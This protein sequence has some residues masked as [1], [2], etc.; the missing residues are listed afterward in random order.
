M[1]YLVLLRGVAGCGKSTWIEQNNLKQYTLCADD[2]R[3]LIQSPV[4]T[5]DGGSEISQ[6]NDKQVWDLLRQLLEKRMERGEFTIIDATH[7]RSSS[8]NE[9]YKK[10]CD[11]YRYRC[12][13]VDFSEISLEV[14]KYRNLSRP[15]YKRVPQDVIENM[16]SRIQTQSLPGWVKGIKPEEF[17]TYFPQVLQPISLSQYND[18][19][20]FGDIHGC[21]DPLMEW[22]TKV[23][24][25]EKTYYIF[26]GDYIDRG[27]Q[28]RETLEFLLQYYNKPNVLMLEGNHERWLRMYANDEE[29]SIRSSEFTRYTMKQLEG[30]DKK[31]LRE[32][33]RKLGQ[34][35]YFLFKNEKFLVTHGGIPTLPS[36]YIASEEYILGVGKYEQYLQVEESFYNKYHADILQVHAHR[37]TENSP[38]SN[39][40]NTCYNL[41]DTVEFGGYLRILSIYDSENGVMIDTFKIKN[42]TF[43]VGETQIEVELPKTDDP[44]EILTQL[45]SNKFIYEKKLTD[46][47]SSFNYTDR[48]FYEKVWNEQTQRARGLFVNTETL[49]VVAR[50]YDKFFNVDENSNMKLN[51]LRRELVFPID[52]YHKYNGFLGLVGFDSEND[53]LF[54]S[55]KSSNK[56]D[57]SRWFTEILAGRLDI[58]NTFISYIKNNNVCFVFEVIDMKNDPHIIDYGDLREVIL[59]DV[60]YR[61]FDYKKYSYSQL[62]EVGKIFN[63]PVKEKACTLKDYNELYEMYENSKNNFDVREGEGYVLEDARG[64]MFKMK[65][66]YYKFWKFMRG[67]KQGIGAGR[68]IDTKMF[69]TPMQNEVYAFMKSLGR[70]VCKEKSIIEIRKMYEGI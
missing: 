17:F 24:F 50:S 47:I 46:H 49:D 68:T 33:C 45:R 67:V 55:S 29:E 61:S 62:Q 5:V 7:S 70:D 23:P 14:I 21:L 30:M 27:I 32:F 56:S 66:A 10:L 15:H 11:K 12:F 53:S 3:L 40:Y 63:L 57:F 4:L 58:V 39:H 38:I 13:V 31:Q 69:I 19:Q 65:S 9:N 42:N 26:T 18:V 51:V 44:K 8:I 41:C 60:I 59:L 20:I 64:Y 35:A 43:F 37:N 2:I 6:K 16:Y 34:L 22:F 54:I 36:P 48:A 28:N 25:S 52:V 1:R